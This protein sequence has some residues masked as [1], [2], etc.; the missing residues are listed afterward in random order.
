MIPI[1]NVYYMLAYAFQTLKSQGYRRLSTEEFHNVAEL[2]AAILSHAFAAQIK[3]GLK[4]EYLEVVAPVAAP[5]GKIEL[6]ETIK[7][8]ALRRRR[9]VCAFDEF[10]VNSYLNRIVK[11]TVVYLLRADLSSRRKNELKRLR[12]YLGAVEPLNLHKINWNI[13]Y[14]KNSQTYRAIVGICRLVL[15]GLLQTKRDGTALLLDFFDEQ[16]MCR[17]Y[18]KFVYEYF[19][20][21]YPSIAT[22]SSFIS[23]SLDDDA[24]E[25]LPIM[26][27]DVMLK[28]K[29]RTLIIDAKYYAQSMSTYFGKT[30]LHSQ[31]LYQI[32]SYVKNFATS[33][34]APQDVAG[35]LLYAQTDESE[36]FRYDYRMSGNRIGARSLDLNRPFEIIA[37]QLNEIA[38][39][40]L[41]K[42]E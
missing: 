29:K 24:S 14:T 11:T 5:R 21:E 39:E 34:K 27:T 41:L 19:R 40:F 3:R 16:R 12:D 36:A 17:L 23:W 33:S 30:T 20:Q 1:Q 10:S 38:D 35:L 18:E 8:N 6:A 42:T 15:E 26:K 25:A 13:R 7:S 2:C 4:R 32:F 22:S 9:A 31:N 28:Y 37:R